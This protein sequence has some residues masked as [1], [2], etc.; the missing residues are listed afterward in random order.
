[1][2]EVSTLTAPPQSQPN[3]FDE[4]RWV[5]RTLAG[6]IIFGTLGNF[7]SATSFFR[8]GY[9]LLGAT[10]ATFSLIGA[11][12]A[13][14]ALNTRRTQIVAQLTAVLFVA[15]V[16]VFLV[17]T[18]GRNPDAIV[19]FTIFPTLFVFFLG[20]RLGIIYSIAGLAAISIPMIYFWLNPQVQIIAPLQNG[21][22]ILI[23]TV[24]FVYF[25][26][27][28]FNA[29]FQS[30]RL[31]RIHA[32]ETLTQQLQNQIERA[33]KLELARREAEEHREELRKQIMHAS[34]LASIGEL[35][36]GVAHEVNNPLMAM[37]A[38]LDLL[39]GI[40]KKRGLWDEEIRTILERQTEATS[41]IRGIVQGLTNY[42]RVDA[43][44]NEDFNV[45]Q[46]IQDT[47]GLVE[48]LYRRKQIEIVCTLGAH[49]PYVHGNRGKFCQVLMNLLNNAADAVMCC[50]EKR[51]ALSTTNLGNDLQFSITDTGCG[52]PCENLDKIFQ[53][54]FT[55]KAP[56][57]GTGLGLSLS[58]S[59]VRQMGG[60]IEVSS[61]L[62][63][64]TT[65]T[66]SLP[67]VEAPISTFSKG[68]SDFNEPV[69]L[70]PAR[71]LLVDDER[72]IGELFKYVLREANLE[73]DYFDNATQALLA[74]HKTQYD[75][76]IVDYFLP[77][78]NGEQF[79]ERMREASTRQ[80]K[81]LLIT[82][83][84][85]APLTHLTD[86][87]NTDSVQ[88]LLKPFSEQELMAALA[89]WLRE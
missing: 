77:D 88:T 22:E 20:N 42:A 85:R 73:L 2:A 86:G 69:K 9:S 87:K 1:M 52:I 13:T 63:C 31:R 24:F 18:G 75:V 23:A 46:A 6:F 21:P 41:R 14:I 62:D 49:R 76:A 50:G 19:H 4:T 26:Q 64:G 28:A 81:I 34:K 56:G 12:L 84:P 45:H 39:Y 27:L 65:F 3:H 58:S 59:I 5:Q 38:N 25:V 11:T 40:L 37:R 35:A 36:S 57:K 8:S 66:I 29:L 51:I 55:T 72:D 80:P 78:M 7:S 44:T 74:A 16:L 82:G 10:E 53:P 60:K 32:L 43:E 54:Y 71:I 67:A 68:S 47:I 15:H 33:R 61:A 48:T 30:G 17:M 79:V 83:S 70:R 89:K